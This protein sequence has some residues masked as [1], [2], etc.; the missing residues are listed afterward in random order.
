MARQDKEFTEELKCGHCQNTAI[1]EIVARYSGVKT[2]TDYSNSW[3]AGPIYQLC[4]CP[5]CDNVTL[6]SC[7]WAEQ[8]EPDDLNWKIFYPQGR[9][10]RGLPPKI[11]L[12]YN[13]ALKVRTIEVNAYGVLI[14]RV[15]D[16]VC[17]DRAATG[18]TL[19]QK[20]ENLAAR[21]EIPTKLVDVATGL[22][23]LRN[24]GA[25]AD[26]GELTDAD[27]PVVDGLARAILEY[28]YTAPLLVQEAQQRLLLLTGG[29][30]V[31]V[32]PSE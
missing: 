8:M 9:D 10:L 19:D 18:K 29:K 7:D 13:A 27:L 5:A 28:V 3:D 23:R 30:A 25:H 2:F 11:G 32:A 20:L 6:R 4:R 17:V 24:V 15:L 21:G 12:A 14:G 1:M 22:R 26:L 31:G 16:L